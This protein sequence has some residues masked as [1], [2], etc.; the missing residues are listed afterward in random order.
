[1]GAEEYELL[2]S[3]LN[4]LPILK[5]NLKSK[6]EELGLARRMVS[7]QRAEIDEF[8]KEL[9]TRDLD[10]ERIDSEIE[11]I[12]QEVGELKLGI[13]KESEKIRSAKL[14]EKEKDIDLKVKQISNNQNILAIVFVVIAIFLAGW[15]YQIDKEDYYDFVDEGFDCENGERIHG[16]LV[17]NDE[18]DCSNGHDEKDPW[19]STSDAQDYV[20]ERDWEWIPGVSLLLLITIPKIFIYIHEEF[21]EKKR[22]RVEA[23]LTELI[24]EK[25]EI[26]NTRR[27]LEDKKRH[28]VKKQSSLKSKKGRLIQLDKKLEEESKV[29]DDFEEAVSTY[30][31]SIE[32]LEKEIEDGQ[33]AIKPLIPYSDLL[34]DGSEE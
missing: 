15:S 31:M 8:K 4:K 12:D 30:S 25:R 6:K 28:L 13:D 19:L 7:S 14:G 27:G 1:M 22:R 20:S 21:G 32:S 11:N 10:V 34:L 26:G 5:E 23:M 3:T 17:L 2:V 9:K 29:L 33:N 16:S 24:S 18:D